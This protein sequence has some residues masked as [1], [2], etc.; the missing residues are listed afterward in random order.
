MTFFENP[1]GT[2]WKELERKGDSKD[3]EETKISN[4]KK[5]SQDDEGLNSVV[6]MIDIHYDGNKD[7]EEGIS[8]SGGT[9]D[10]CFFKKIPHN[11]EENPEIKH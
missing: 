6:D 2:S 3:I 7:D 10:G 8:D 4:I 1:E 9:E 5:V 11:L